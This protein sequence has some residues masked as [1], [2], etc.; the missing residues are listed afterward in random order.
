MRPSPASPQSNSYW[1]PVIIL[2]LLA[3][4][5]ALL[6]GSKPDAVLGRWNYPQFYLV[7]GLAGTALGTVILLLLPET[8]RRF[9]GF[10]LIA[11]ALSFVFVLLSLEAVAWLLPVRAQMDNPW[12]LL[13]GLGG[14]SPAEGLP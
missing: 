2:A 8:S 7:V 12:Y 13:P 5:C 3:V 6:P 1:W 9:I 11:V 14:L 4:V 10:R